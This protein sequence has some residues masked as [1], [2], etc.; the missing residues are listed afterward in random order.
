[1][2]Q[3]LIDLLLAFVQGHPWGATALAVMSV[4]R[5]VFKPAIAFL[6]AYVLATPTTKDDDWEREFKTGKLYWLLDLVFSIKIPEK[7]T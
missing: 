7:P 4:C 6:D 5:M 2:E 3:Q 1:M